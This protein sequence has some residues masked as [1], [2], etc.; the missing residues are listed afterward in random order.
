MSIVRDVLKE[1]LGM[2][3]GDTR[4]AIATCF[5]VAAV[6]ALTLGLRV[7]PWVAGGVL[8]VGCLAILAETASHD[9]K[10]GDA[11]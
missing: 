10:G 5:L 6:G 2:F 9:A 8:V 4:L 7:D 11:R 3:V 1:L